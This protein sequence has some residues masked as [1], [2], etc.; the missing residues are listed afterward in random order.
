MFDRL[1]REHGKH[2]DLRF[3]ELCN[4]SVTVYVSNFPATV[5]SLALWK[6]CDRHRSVADVYIAQ[7][8]SKS[9]HHFAFVQFVKIPDSKLLLED[10]NKIWI[11]SYHLFASM[12]RFDRKQFSQRPH[13][14]QFR[15]PTKVGYGMKHTEHAKGNQSYATAVI[16]NS[17]ILKAQY[18]K[19]L[20]KKIVLNQS[21]LLVV[22]DTSCVVLAKASH[23]SDSDEDEQS[24]R[25]N[26]EGEEAEIKENNKDEE[27]INM[28]VDEVTD[29]KKYIDSIGAHGN[30]PFRGHAFT[31]ISG[32]GEKLSRFDRFLLSEDVTNIVP[33]LMAFS[34]DRLI[35]DHRPII[36][37]QSN[38]D[39]GPT[40]FKFYNSWLSIPDFDGMTRKLNASKS[41]EKG[42]LSSKIAEIERDLEAGLGS[43]TLHP[44][45][46]IKDIFWEFFVEK[47]KYFEGVGVTR[48]S[49]HYKTLSSAQVSLH[50]H[51]IFERE[52]YDAIRDCGS[53]KSPSPDGF[54]FA[55]YKKYWDILK[56]DIM[57]YVRE[58]FENGNI[59]SERIMG[60]MGF[61]CHWRGWIRGCLNSAK[62]SILI[63]GSPS[64]EF[65][66]HRG[67]RQGDPLSPFLFILVMEALHVAVEDAINVGLYRG[68]QVRSLHISHLLFAD[69]V[70]FLGEW[71]RSNI[72]RLISLLQCFHDVSGLKINFHKSNLY[73]IGVNN[74]EISNLAS[75]T[76]C[77]PQQLPFTYLGIPIGSNMSRIKGCNP[78][79]DKFKNRLSK[80]KANMLSI[81]GAINTM[82]DKGII[83]HSSIKRQVKDDSTTRFWRDAWLGD[84]PLERKY[85]RVIGSQLDSLISMLANVHLTEGYDAWHWSLIGSNIFTVRDTRIYIDSISL[86]DFPI[87]TRWCRFIPRKVNILVWHVLRDQTPTRWNLSR[88][89]IEVPSFL[90]PLCNISPETSAHLFWSCSMATS[91]W[92]LVFKW[93]DLTFPDSNNLNDVFNWLDD[94][95]LNS[96]SKSILHSIFGVAVWMLWQFRNNKIFRDK[97]MLQRDLLDKIMD[98][99]F[100]CKSEHS[101]VKDVKMRG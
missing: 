20:M 30:V 77:T 25:I 32:N 98:I 73:G 101:E 18:D 52:V 90:C 41:E 93:I 57:A 70:L 78:I 17:D 39:F 63:N 24:I 42:Q 40:P 10:L 75:F 45:R 26:N 51:S 84:I 89:G 28:Q 7:K 61:D 2:K 14:T 27:N 19:L 11:I 94:T 64:F 99:S 29:L 95:R 96:A 74:H 38:V 16:G 55:V 15:I 36:L 59:P 92:H 88:K 62:A 66:L 23:N 48:R 37:M 50:E 87:E 35:S 76:G 5:G 83:P 54:S 56:M 12:A 81:G 82:H 71:S 58:F 60:F 3:E 72:I 8:L 44:R 65:S 6:L 1:G 100:L 86:L 46:D 21:D 68:V 53:E 80:W 9:G 22:P 4:V 85:P 69:D 91:I 34:L 47:F 31:R 13:D 67:L 33:N 97:K 43:S 79:I 49:D